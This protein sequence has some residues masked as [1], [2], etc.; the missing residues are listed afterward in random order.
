MILSLGEPISVPPDVFGV[1]SHNKATVSDDLEAMVESKLAP[2]Y[3]RLAALE[4]QR[5]KPWR[6]SLP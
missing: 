1:A 4:E 5:G 2:I 6:V 3:E